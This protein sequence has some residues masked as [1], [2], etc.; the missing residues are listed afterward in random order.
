VNVGTGEDLMIAEL[1]RLIAQAVGFEGRIVFD[2]SRPDGT[3]RKLVD[4][5]RIAA[6]GWTARIPLRE[7]LVST[8]AWY[9]ENLA[10]A[11]TAAL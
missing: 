7:G 9:R 11:K 1:A 10:T 6:L 2:R 8:C 3:P 5:S 4:V